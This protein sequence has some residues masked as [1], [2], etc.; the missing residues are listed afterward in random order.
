MQ[1][2]VIQS[3]QIVTMNPIT[4]LRST[5]ISLKIIIRCTVTTILKKAKYLKSLSIKL[6]SSNLR[7]T[8][9]SIKYIN[10]HFFNCCLFSSLLYRHSCLFNTK[11]RKH[12][13]PGPSHPNVQVMKLQPTLP[14]SLISPGPLRF[15]TGSLR[16]RILRL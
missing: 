14:T 12:F 9:H 3:N 4:F 16:L 6:Q 11:L 5:L 7:G 10:H 2:P 8:P 1:T 15:S 13:L